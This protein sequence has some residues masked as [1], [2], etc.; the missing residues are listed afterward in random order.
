MRAALTSNPAASSAVL[1]ALACAGDQNVL[2]AV[3]ENPNCPARVL[4]WLIGSDAY[5]MYD[6]YDPQIAVAVAGHPSPTM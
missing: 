1:A 4:A 6:M 5:D 3:A 2:I